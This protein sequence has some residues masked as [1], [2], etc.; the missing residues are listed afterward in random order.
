MPERTW[1]SSVVRASYALIIAR[2]VSSQILDNLKLVF[3]FP[4]L[5]K[6][7]FFVWGV[8]SSVE[9]VGEAILVASGTE[10]AGVTGVPFSTTRTTLFPRLE[11][12][13]FFFTLI[14]AYIS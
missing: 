13:S 9:V 2:L 8:I 14:L 5:A 4:L 6:C 1:K 11:R 12:G 7:G 3:F 10:V